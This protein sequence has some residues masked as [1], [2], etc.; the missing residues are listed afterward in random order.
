MLAL[1][2]AEEE[3]DE[4]RA[5]AGG[6]ADRERALQRA[7]LGGDLVE[8]LLFEREHPLG[9]AVEAQARLGRLDAPA[10]AVEERLAEALLERTHL[11]ADRGL[12]HAELLRRL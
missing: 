8:Q 6:G 9:A 10:G 5:G 1:K 12:R 3:R 2:V 4:M 11:E 7:A